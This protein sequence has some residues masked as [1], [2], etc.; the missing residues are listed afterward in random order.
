MYLEDSWV[1]EVCVIPGSLRIKLDVVLCE[2]HQDYTPPISGEQ[3]CYRD[4]VILMDGIS[5]LTWDT[6]SLSPAFDAT[7]E[8][9]YGSIDTFEQ[10]GEEYEITGDLGVITLRSRMAPGIVLV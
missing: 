3:Y 1:L 4:G 7:G 5:T 2:G 6:T 9:D 8:M 10:R